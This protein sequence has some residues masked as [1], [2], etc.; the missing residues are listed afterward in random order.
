MWIWSLD[1]VSFVSLDKNYELDEPLDWM[2][3]N[4]KSTSMF[5]YLIWDN[6]QL[7]VELTKSHVN[8]FL[9]LSLQRLLN[10]A[11]ENIRLSVGR[12]P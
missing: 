5:L 2:R 12:G 3:G 9:N 11:I 8:I 7:K 6:F 1:P 10:E 4:F